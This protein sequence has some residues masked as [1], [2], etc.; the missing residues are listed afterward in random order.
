M[1]QLDRL[2]IAEFQARP[3]L[4]SGDRPPEMSEPR[5]IWNL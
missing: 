5:L 2:L 3:L 4:T 1:S